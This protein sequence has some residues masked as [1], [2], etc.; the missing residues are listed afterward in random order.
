MKAFSFLLAALAAPALLCS[1]AFAEDPAPEALKG[2]LPCNGTAIQGTVVRLERDPEFVKLHQAA[3]QRFAQLPEDKQKA[4]AEASDP[5][6]LMEY[7]ADLWPDK[8]EYEQYVANWKKTRI[9]GSM[10]V[11][12]GLKKTGADTYAVLSATKVGDNGNVL[13]I[14]IGALKYNATK[15]VWISNN[16][17]LTA[18]PFSADANY[19]FGAQTGTEWKLEKEDS[20]SKLVEYV[21]VSKTTDG[22]I[23]Y[24]AYALTEISAIS[25][26]PIANHGY[27]LLFPMPT[28]SAN[29]A[30]PG[31]K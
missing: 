23:V 25:G 5:S 12:L 10:D 17:E 19:D 13:P 3:Q 27:M 9:I 4:I 2:M 15:N 14:T 22:K 21:R 16:G 29:A 7:N 18:T 6:R 28:A 20:L 11:A 8:A 31:Q 26:S 1:T 30:K 24:V